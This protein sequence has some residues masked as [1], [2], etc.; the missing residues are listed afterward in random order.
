LW[1]ANSKK[2]ACDFRIMHDA[3]DFLQT[4]PRNFRIDMDKPKGVA[5]R[6]A[7]SGIHLNRPTRLAYA[8]LIAKA[9]REI[10]SAI[11]APTVGDDNLRFWRSVTQ[12]LKKWA[13]EGRLIKDRHND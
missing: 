12:M 6:G 1:Q 2:T 4:T 3:L 7:C 11:G 5:V 9:G 8:K 10:S 13:Y